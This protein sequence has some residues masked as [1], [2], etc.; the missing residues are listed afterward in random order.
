MRG[1]WPA[2]PAPSHFAMEHVKNH[3]TTGFAVMHFETI[4]A[5]RRSR[6]RGPAPPLWEPF[7]LRNC[8]PAEFLPFSSG[9]TCYANGRGNSSVRLAD[10]QQEGRFDHSAGGR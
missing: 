1:R 3:A 9:L 8:S 6:P 7:I 5:E 2:G 10:S 4:P